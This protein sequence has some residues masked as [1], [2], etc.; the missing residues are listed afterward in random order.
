MGGRCGRGEHLGVPGDLRLVSRPEFLLEF[1]HERE[2]PPPVQLA[3]DRGSHER[4]HVIVCNGS[5]VP[6]EIVGETDRKLC[7][8]LN[9]T[10]VGTTVLA[11]PHA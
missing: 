11:L 8:V 4:A 9:P 3:A 2:E 10:R 7:H 5:K 1:G 6:D